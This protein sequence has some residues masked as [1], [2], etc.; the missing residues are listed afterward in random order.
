MRTGIEMRPL[1]G[2]A[3]WKRTP[4][5]VILIA[6]TLL[7]APT[8]ALAQAQA[9]NGVI[10]GTVTD[11]SGSVVAGARVK[12]VNL[13]NGISREVTTNESGFYRAPLLPLGRYEIIV[14]QTG[15]NRFAQTG[16]TL[17]AGQAATIDVALKVGAVANEVTI[18]S[19]APIA[20]SS[21]IELGRT[22]SQTE[23]KN[24]P[25]PSRNPYN[26][27]LLQPGVNG[28]EN[29]E[30]GVPRFNANGY[31]SRINYQLDGSTNTQKDRAGLRLTP[32]SEVFV[33]EV[34]VVSNGFAPEFGQTSGVVYNAITPSGTNQ[35]H[36]TGAY[37]LRR[38]SFVARPFFLRPDIAKA[39]PGLDNPIFSLGGPLVR[40]KAHFY[41]GYEHVDRQLQ[42]D[43]V[44]TVTPANA[45]ALGLPAPV[46]FIPA[47]Q[48]TNF[49]IVRPD[50]KL[51]NSNELFGRYTLFT[52]NSPNNIGGGLNTLQRSVDFT[53]NIQI[54]NGQLVSIV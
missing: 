12:I 20:D 36:G 37:F 10:E 22:I 18:T 8:V 39:D 9:A 45:T 46:G 7:L 4:L 47:S 28:F 48:I 21:K 15:F 25:L 43:R 52:N 51:N 29:V 5:A 27:G 31:K 3:V 53:D 33:R 19:D 40:D 42:Q 30:F 2:D 11:P 1:T 44:V 17:S 6:L 16:I 13:D 14:E 35:F 41:V 26:F 32:I 34:Q 50:W 23:V 49:F 54:A 24:L 38:K